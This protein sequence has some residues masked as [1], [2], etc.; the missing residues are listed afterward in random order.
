LKDRGCQAVV[1]LGIQ[2]CYD[3]MIYL[4][5]ASQIRRASVMLALS[6]IA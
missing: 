5:I 6:Y 2:F 1:S 4:G 3:F